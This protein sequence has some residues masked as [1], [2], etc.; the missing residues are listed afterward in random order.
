MAVLLQLLVMQVATA[1][2]QTWC[3]QGLSQAALQALLAAVAA[4]APSEEIKGLIQKLQASADGVARPA[5]SSTYTGSWEL[6]WDFSVSPHMRSSA[7][8]RHADDP[9]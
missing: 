3:P 1:T 9:V 5:Q 6:L 2:D 8:W 4:K 7:S